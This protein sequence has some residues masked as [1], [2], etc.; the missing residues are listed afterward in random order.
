M[1]PSADDAGDEAGEGSSTETG[2]EGEAAA[3]AVSKLNVQ[4]PAATAA[5]DYDPNRSAVVSHAV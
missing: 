2:S 5:T 1:T 3:V 4:P